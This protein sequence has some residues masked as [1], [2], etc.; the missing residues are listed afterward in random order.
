MGVVEDGKQCMAPVGHGLHAFPGDG[1]QW[2]HRRV[3]K[4][5]KNVVLPCMMV[6]FTTVSD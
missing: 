5:S 6:I 1:V 4:S 2:K 3:L